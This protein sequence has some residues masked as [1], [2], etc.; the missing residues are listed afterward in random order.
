MKNKGQLSIEKETIKCG[1][2][3]TA[4]QY[5]KHNIQNLIFNIQNTSAIESFNFLC[6]HKKLLF[7]VIFRTWF[8]Q[9]IIKKFE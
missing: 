8:F 9:V 2:I 1:K 7:P 6:K 3:I 5:S 4:G